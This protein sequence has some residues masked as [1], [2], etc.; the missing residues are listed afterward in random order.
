MPARLLIVDD[1][2]PLLSLLK[3]Y[4]ERLGYEVDLAGTAEE[5]LAFFESDP[6]RY[7]C[8]LTDLT[9]P[10]INGEELVERMR[11]LNPRLPA[12]ISSGY[13]YQP[14]PSKARTDFL[15]KPYLPQMLVEAIQGI[16]GKSAK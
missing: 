10:G 4:M 14:K 8:V 12:L 6:G 11:S 9:L 5:A 1:E 7:A 13:P 16:L 3:R 15:Q 2:K